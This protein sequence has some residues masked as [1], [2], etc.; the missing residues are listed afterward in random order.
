MPVLDSVLVCAR[1]LAQHPDFEDL[2]EA[3][4]T[5][6]QRAAFAGLELETARYDWGS[7]VSVHADRLT[8]QKLMVT[9]GDEADWLVVTTADG[10]Y[11]VAR[12]VPG[13]SRRN[14]MMLGGLTGADLT[15]RDSPAVRI[16]NVED[17]LQTIA[18]G[19]L[20]RC[21]D[22]L[23]AMEATKAITVDVLRRRSR[24]RHRPAAGLIDRWPLPAGVTDSQRPPHSPSRSSRSCSEHAGTRPDRASPATHSRPTR[25]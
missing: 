4:M 13:M 10:L 8:G 14:T 11:L 17:N 9:G 25:R 19:V 3:L 5:G 21:A 7:G 23:G 15:F 18:R 24:H 2:G 20:G 16:G 6:R 1:L 12:D 22:A